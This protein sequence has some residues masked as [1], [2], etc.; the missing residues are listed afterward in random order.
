M[1]LSCDGCI[2]DWKPVNAP[3]FTSSGSKSSRLSSIRTE[4]LL[5]KFF[6]STLSYNI[7]PA[8]FLQHG[9][10]L[11]EGHCG[12]VRYCRECLPEKFRHLEGRTEQQQSDDIYADINNGPIITV[13]IVNMTLMKATLMKV[14]LS[15]DK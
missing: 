9:W 8:D 3:I 12:P 13:M 15:D 5:G 11:D 2:D 4:K 1:D 7:K 14:T 6:S 10:V